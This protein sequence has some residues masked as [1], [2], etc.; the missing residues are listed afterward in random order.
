MYVLNAREGGEKDDDNERKE[1]GSREYLCNLY[2]VA[3]NREDYAAF[4]FHSFER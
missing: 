3:G 2:E 4:I 1:T